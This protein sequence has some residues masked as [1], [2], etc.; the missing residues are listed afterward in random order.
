M[1]IIFASDAYECWKHWSRRYRDGLYKLCM[2]DIFH[3]GYGVVVSHTKHM[4]YVL[5]NPSLFKKDK[6]FK[7]LFPLMGDGVLSSN[8]KEH[9]FQKRLLGKAFSPDH[10]RKFMPV[11]NDHAK[12]LIDVYKHEV[13]DDKTGKNIE[14]QHHLSNIVF[15]IF[16]D[17]AFGH[18]YD[19]L[20]SDNDVVNIIKRQIDTFANL[21]YQS[22]RVVLTALWLAKPFEKYY[23]DIDRVRVEQIVDDIILKKKE[24]LAVEE[25]SERHNDLLSM[26][27]KAR[28]DETRARFTDK[29]LRDNVFTLILAS[30]ET[31][32]TAIPWVLFALATNTEKQ[33]LARMEIMEIMEDQTDIDEEGMSRLKYTT[34]CIKEAL[35][36]HTVAPLTS[37]VAT[38]DVEIGGYKLKAG[39]V[40]YPCFLATH[41][42]DDI[43][44]N[45]DE[46]LPERFLLTT[47]QTP[48]SFVAF[49]YGPYSCIGRHFAMVEI[50]IILCHI[51]NNFYVTA[52]PDFQRYNRTSMVTAKTDRPIT[53]RLTPI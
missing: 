51:L 31:T 21:K 41:H 23:Q 10:I 52:D 37:R 8:G 20:T 47:E 28:D 18:N 22:L 1:D 50:K 33:D 43:Y 38:K 32:G 27:I 39:T 11:M 4:R 48:C 6:F 7:T 17:T 14:V 36:L 35:R 40:L 12:R 46:Y 16:C 5:G 49:G 53:L 15:D 44:E 19:A 29:L 30:F 42:Q 45:S 2:V 13:G 3:G 9:A 25:E 34:A 24:A 26:M